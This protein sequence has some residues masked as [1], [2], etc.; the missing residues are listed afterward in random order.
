MIAP[1][2][3]AGRLRKYAT[4]DVRGMAGDT[5]CVEKKLLSAAAD[6]V[7]ML[8]FWPPC[9]P[10][11]WIYHVHAVWC[12]KDKILARLDHGIEEVRFAPDVMWDFYHCKFMP[13]YFLT[14]EEAKTELEEAL[15]PK[16]KG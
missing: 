16:Q 9:P 14:M 11:A 8:R 6:A 15:K 12:G 13:H 3:L 7:D 1:E 4:K 5:I 2:E 10:N